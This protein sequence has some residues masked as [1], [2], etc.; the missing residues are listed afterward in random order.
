MTRWLKIYV[1]AIS[2]S[3]CATSAQDA[4]LSMQGMSRGDLLA[5]AGA[6]HRQASDG[7]LQV[8]T[9]ER[10]RVDQYGSAH[11]DTTVTLIDGRVSSVTYSRASRLCA[12]SIRNCLK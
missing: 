1:A 5:C 2:L 9:Y 6:P 12:D 3:G 11:C 8:L 4:R 7:N 10:F